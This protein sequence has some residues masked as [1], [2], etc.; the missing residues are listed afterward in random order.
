MRLRSYLKDFFIPKF[1]F[2]LTSS[3]ATA[4]DYGIYIS[5][6]M[7]AHFTET[8]SHAISYTV[9]MVINFLLQRKFIFEN[10]RKT[11]YAFILSVIFSLIGWLLSQAVFN[12]LIH[13][14]AFFRHYDLLAKVVVTATIFLYN[15]YTKRFSFEKKMPW[16]K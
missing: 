6:T 9:A 2:A 16:M 14:V 5:L 4:V 15:F 8:T 13:Y 10:N 12:L 1:K 11:G 3:I 7:M